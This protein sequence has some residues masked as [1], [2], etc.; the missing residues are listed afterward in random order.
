M[1]DLIRKDWH[2]IPFSDADFCPFVSVWSNIEDE[3]LE[4]KVKN[5]FNLALDFAKL[6]KPDFS[7]AFESGCRADGKIDWN[8]SSLPVGYFEYYVRSAKAKFVGIESEKIT[9]DIGYGYGY[10]EEESNQ[11]SAIINGLFDDY[12]LSFSI[13]YSTK[14]LNIYSEVSPNESQKLQNFVNQR[15]IQKK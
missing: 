2:E 11:I 8:Y 14:K 10:G 1:S 6:I 5:V 3:I 12:R 4:D 13:H 7:V 15:F 9:L